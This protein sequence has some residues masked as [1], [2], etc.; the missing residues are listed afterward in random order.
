VNAVDLEACHAADRDA[1]VAALAALLLE[2]LDAEERAGAEVGT[3][4]TVG[5]AR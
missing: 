3:S 2:A 4:E 1:V 5:D